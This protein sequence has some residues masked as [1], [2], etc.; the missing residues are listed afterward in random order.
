MTIKDLAYT[1]S[2][3]SSQQE[4]AISLKKKKKSITNLKR[5]G[6]RDNLW[7]K[8]HHLNQEDFG[9]NSLHL[10]HTLYLILTEKSKILNLAQEILG[11]RITFRSVSVSCERT[12]W[13]AAHQA[14][15]SMGFSRQ[16]YLS[17]LLCPTPGDIPDL[18]I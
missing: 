11:C 8:T 16:E 12:P 18:G 17:G 14:P 10:S 15:L 1:W 9:E 13:T 2:R 7:T 4:T 6:K 3:V 5:W